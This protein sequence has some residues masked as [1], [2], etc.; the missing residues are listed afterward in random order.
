[1]KIVTKLIA[2]SAFAGSS[3]ALANDPQAVLD[4]CCELGAACCELGMP[5]CDDE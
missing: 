5:C 4:A 3:A 2:L 1:M